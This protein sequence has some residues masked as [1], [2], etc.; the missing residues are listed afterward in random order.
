[1]VNELQKR[2][3][4][5]RDTYPQ[6]RQRLEQVKYSSGKNELLAMCSSGISPLKLSLKACRKEA[7]GAMEG[8]GE[9]VTFTNANSVSQKYDQ[10]THS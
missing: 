4:E 3:G 2:G 6:L 8:Q 10:L 9:S 1:M 5:E 7:G